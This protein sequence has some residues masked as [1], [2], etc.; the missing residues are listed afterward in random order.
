MS[1]LLYALV[2]PL[3]LLF[4]IP[5]AALALLTTTLA[6]STL[7][8][9]VLIV[10]IELALVVAH[11]QFFNRVSSKIAQPP[12]QGSSS[13]AT[14]G[15]QRIKSRR[16][17]ACSAGSEGMITPKAGDS[18]SFGLITGTG[19]NRD[20]EGVGGWRFSGPGEEDSQWTAMNSRLELPAAVGEFKRKH[21][22]SLTSGGFSTSN[23]TG[24]HHPPSCLSRSAVQ[25][26]ARTPPAAHIAGPSSPGEYF[27]TPPLSRSTPTF[28][29]AKI[30][31]AIFHRK[32]S[33]SSTLSSG[34]SNRGLHIQLPNG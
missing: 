25:S 16:S 4:S 6:F 28:D 9:R 32:T 26:R 27:M 34:S 17:S 21:N 22:R 20:F 23:I 13:S 8:V 15:H 2:P 1:T 3:L 5:L 30:G 31:K 10:Y 33:S 24:D 29:T 11:N 12:V 14:L 19:I 18:G 7:C